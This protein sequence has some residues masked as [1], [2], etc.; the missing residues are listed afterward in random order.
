MKK[1]LSAMALGLA[2]VVGVGAEAA[3]EGTGRGNGD[4][5]KVQT[6]ANWYTGGKES[7]TLASCHI[8]GGR[9][10]ILYEVYDVWLDGK[11]VGQI[12]GLGYG[13]AKST[14]KF[15]LSRNKIH[16]FKIKYN[17]KENARLYR[18][19]T[20]RN[21]RNQPHYWNVSST[22]KVANYW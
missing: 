15:E 18:E 13:T 5:M 22:T 1:L 9:K 3:T 11:Y 6:K 21:L 12:G 10:G 14:R 8:G 2:L 19:N 7:I 16:T 20:G 4:I 17:Y